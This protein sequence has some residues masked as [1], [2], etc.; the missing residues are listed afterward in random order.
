[1]DKNQAVNIILENFNLITLSKPTNSKFEK[2][3]ILPDNQ[4][5]FIEEFTKTQSFHKNLSKMELENFLQE[6]IGINFNYFALKYMLVFAL[7]PKGGRYGKM[8]L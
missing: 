3:R 6:N 2:I 4:S 7:G 8:V 5:F 1:M